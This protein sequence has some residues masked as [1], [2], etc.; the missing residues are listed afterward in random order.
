LDKVPFLDLGRQYR[1]IQTEIQAAIAAVLEQ[2]AFSGGPFVSAF[3]RNFANAHDARF[4]AGVNNGTAAL[5][6]PLMALGVG[7]GDEVIVPANTFIAT[8]EAVSLCG[9]TPVFV[10][11]DPV[12]YNLDPD[13]AAA[14]IT[15][16]TR[17]LIA[18]H[19]YGHPAPLDALS[20]LTQRHG[21]FLM[22]DCA[23]AHLTEYKGR[24][25]GTT[26]VAGCFSFYPGKNLGAYGEAGAVLTQD[27]ALFQAVQAIKCHG[28][29]VKYHH[30][31][32][33]HNYRMEGLQGAI[34]D[35]KL[36][37]LEGWTQ[38]R[39]QVAQW[40]RERLA[41]VSEL[42]L[43]SEAPDCRHVYHLFIVQAAQR[44]ALAQ[45]LKEANIETGLHYPVP[46]PQQPAYAF[47]NYRPEDTPVAT[48]VSGKLLSLPM[49]P[50]LRLEEVERVCTAIRRF[51]GR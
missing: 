21:L 35:V 13:R 22:E 39:C 48:R 9:A 40:Y 44:D 47:L 26:G 38:A 24:K 41:D 2:S 14:A 4:C 43:P 25:V 28:S 37:Y 8:A 16:K 1:A 34:L 18:V 32:I 17:G 49:F 51:Y 27:E 5:H 12:Y 3:E 30:E 31:R 42:I 11:C 6:A 10:D 46:C 50:E 23:Q 45:A 33:G 15:P 7:P 29:H 20:A 19:L 36:R